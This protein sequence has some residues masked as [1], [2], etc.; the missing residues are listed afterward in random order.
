MAAA[1]ITPPDGLSFVGVD[2]EAEPLADR[3][4]AQG[5]DP[6]APAMVSWLGVSMYLT[7]EAVAATLATV[8]GLAAGTELVMEYAL[9][10]DLRDEAGRAYASFALPVAEQRGEPWLSFLTPEQLAA[11]LEDQST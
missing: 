9:P 2:L 6:S 8:G 3:L 7:A 10:P 1:R 11:L 4:A 5:F